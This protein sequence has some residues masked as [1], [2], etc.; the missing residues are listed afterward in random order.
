MGKIRFF[1]V[2]QDGHTAKEELITAS[3]HVAQE[4]VRVFGE[5]IELMYCVLPQ[6]D[7][8]ARDLCEVIVDMA[9]A[10]VVYFCQDCDCNKN[11]EILRDLAQEYH[12]YILDGIFEN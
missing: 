9:E 6:E 3:D 11:T 2:S 10:D 4:A 1:I 7:W 12:L 5:D 8:T